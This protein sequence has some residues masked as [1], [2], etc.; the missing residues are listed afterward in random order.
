M[1]RAYLIVFALVAVLGLGLTM[2]SIPSVLAND[3]NDDR[4]NAVYAPNENVLGMSYGDWSAAWWQYLL[5]FTNDVSPYLDTTGQYCNEGQGGPVFFLV[6]GPVNPTIRSCTVP[7]G[8]A[9]FAPIINV[10]CS[11]VEPYPFEGKNDQEAR[12]CAA[13]WND[14]TD[15]RRL[16]FTI[17]GHMVEGLGDFRVQ[18]PY[19]Y[20][21][22]MPPT[23]NFLGVDGATE[24]YSVSDG[25]WV[26]VQPLKPGK[27]VIHFEGYWTSGPGAGAV[28]NV[29]YYLTVTP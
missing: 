1:K 16:K 18:S 6:G 28:Q 24:G 27:H 17:D 4:H 5:L 23:N 21:N 10:E 15:I 26:M 14:G 7:A 29:T 22:M 9:L 25:Y 3:R 13:S 12:V 11:S 2:L 20:F 8:K 19:Y